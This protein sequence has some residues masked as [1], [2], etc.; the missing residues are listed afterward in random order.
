MAQSITN[1]F[2]TEWEDLVKQDYQQTESHLRKAVRQKFQQGAQII[3]FHK[4]GVGTATDNKP[5]HAPLV[6]MNVQHDTVQAIMEPTH[7]MELVESLDELMTNIDTRS[8]YSKLIAAALNRKLDDKIIAKLATTSNSATLPTANTLDA[9]ALAF[10]SGKLG[11][12]KVPMDGERYLVV[13]Q[14]GLQDMIADAK[15]AS[16]DYLSKEAYTKGF[17]SGVMGFN[18]IVLTDETLLPAVAGNK[19]TCFAFHKQSIG[20]GV[21][22]DVKLEVEKRVD[23]SN[24]QVLGQLL[25]GAVKIDDAG[26]F[27]FDVSDVA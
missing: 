14:G 10:L 23:L 2:V 21:A 1:A 7:A 16:N 20:L 9:A 26:I 27:K 8:E 18:V 24:W 22:Q 6:P 12:N 4:L 13:S 11:Q 3:K 17:V 5:R 25:T 19:R 15:I